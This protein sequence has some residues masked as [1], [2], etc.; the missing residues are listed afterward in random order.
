M[1]LINK[2][3]DRRLAVRDE[4]VVAS[5]LD[6]RM[7]DTMPVDAYLKQDNRT[8]SEFLA[9]KLEEITIISSENE[10]PNVKSSVQNIEL[11]LISE[12]RHQSNSNTTE[13]EILEYLALKNIR[14]PNILI[15]WKEHEKI[16]PN[17]AKLA[18]KFLCITATSGKTESFFSL[19]GMAI[20]AKRSTLSPTKAEMIMFIHENQYIIDEKQ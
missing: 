10:K 1:E 18:K 16:F 2:N 4:M 11:V 20:K 13:G 17:L 3:L 19:M 15:W 12:Y 14:E 9:S 5:L 8:K 6:P 7:K